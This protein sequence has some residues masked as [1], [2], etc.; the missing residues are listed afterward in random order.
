MWNALLGVAVCFRRGAVR[1]VCF[2]WTRI[3]IHLFRPQSLER[4]L[5]PMFTFA[6]R[7]VGSTR[8]DDMFVFLSF[9]EVNGILK[10]TAIE[11]HSIHR[12]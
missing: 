1:G 5:G 3:L 2:L 12:A 6:G 9:F 10:D 11:V 8:L 4:K 7:G